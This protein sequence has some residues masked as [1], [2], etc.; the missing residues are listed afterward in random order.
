MVVIKTNQVKKNLEGNQKK[1]GKLRGG[2][3]NNHWSKQRD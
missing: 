2:C 1:I 3:G